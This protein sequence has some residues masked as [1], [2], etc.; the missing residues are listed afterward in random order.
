MQPLDFDFLKDRYDFELQRKEEITNALGLPVGILGGLGSVIAIMAQTFSYRGVALTRTF[1]VSLAA[2]LVTFLGCLVLLGCAYHR[3]K[4]VFLPLLEDLERAKVEFLEF[5]NHVKGS[6]GALIADYE[7][8]FRRSIMRAA[9]QNTQNND[10]RIGFLYWARICL[11]G[12][13]G[14]T[15]MTG[16][17]FVI[18]QV[19]F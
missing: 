17:F 12:V 5:V 14:T 15:A 19:R 11:F 1:G 10:E 9:D 4:Y 3:Q 2:S 16:I 6:G 18:D 7:T 13:L 8:E